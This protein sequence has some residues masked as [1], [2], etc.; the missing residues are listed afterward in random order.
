MTDNDKRVELTLQQILEILTL[1]GTKLI[2]KEGEVPDFDEWIFRAEESLRD[3][4][5]FP[6]LTQE[7]REK[8]KIH[9]FQN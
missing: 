3:M 9:F 2:A 6:E 4:F 1:T 7:S 5:I 8:V